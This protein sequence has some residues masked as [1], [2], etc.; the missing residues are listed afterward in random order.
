MLQAPIFAVTTL[1]LSRHG[2]DFEGGGVRFDA[3]IE[4]MGQKDTSPIVPP[5]GHGI[6]FPGQT[7]HA[8][9]PLTSGV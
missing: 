1:N 2:K 5:Q 6:I 3:P 9:V 4:S 7:L 8:S